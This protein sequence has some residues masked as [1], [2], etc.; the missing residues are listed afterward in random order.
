[1]AIRTIK[2]TVSVDGISPECY[3]SGGV[4]GEH[5]ATE[6]EFNLESPLLLAI[7]NRAQNSKVMYRFEGY[8]AIGTKNST[9][10]Q[11]LGDLPLVFPLEYWL[12]KDGGNI[13]VHLV[14]SV[15][16]DGETLMDIYSFPALITLLSV[17]D[18]TYTDGENYE[19]ITLLSESARDAAKTAKES[20]ESALCNA[21]R[22]EAAKISLEDGAEIIF[23][24]GDAKTALDITLAIDD[25]VNEFSPNPVQN[26]AIYNYL[27]NS[28]EQLSKNILLTA[29]PVGSY[30]WSTKSDNPAT[31]FGGTW[32]QVTDKFILAAGDEYTVGTTG[33]N[34]THTHTLSSGYA[35]IGQ[36]L[37]EPSHLAYS[38]S[39]VSGSYGH[40][41]SHRVQANGLTLADTDE[42]MGL[43]TQLAGSTAYADNMPPFETAYCFKRTA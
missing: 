13:R 10:P 35:L 27:K 21:E 20:A 23:C 43:V 25:Q 5:N 31:L 14:I 40:T 32:E 36:S 9:E 28:L 30:Y 19:S 24:G 26:S 3:M 42:K 22:T 39:E 17:P 6:L 8:T 34:K 33:G 16:K 18:A 38:A 41:A 11:E 4:M 37:A 29:H 1:M 15:L 7:E 12:T 2:Y